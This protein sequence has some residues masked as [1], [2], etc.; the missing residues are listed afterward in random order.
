ME[1]IVIVSVLKHNVIILCHYV[2]LLETV[3]MRLRLLPSIIFTHVCLFTREGVGWLPRMYNWSHDGGG[4]GCIWKE[5]VCIRGGLFRP[6]PPKIYMGYGQQAGST[7]PTGMH[8]CYHCYFCLC[9]CYHT[10]LN[11]MHILV[12]Y[13]FVGVVLVYGKEGVNLH[14][15][16]GVIFTTCTM[17]I[18]LHLHKTWHVPL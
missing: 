3:A 6:P 8:S 10:C 5:G 13:I 4:G 9:I 1:E 12:V 7:H 17:I 14:S 11:N 18:Y 15:H 2:I 16:Q